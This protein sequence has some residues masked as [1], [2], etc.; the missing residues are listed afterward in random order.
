MK[1]LIK[2]IAKYEGKKHQ[3]SVGD[4]RE[5][6]RIIVCGQGCGLIDATSAMK[7]MLDRDTLKFAGMKDKGFTPEQ[8]FNNLI[9]YDPSK[10]NK[11]GKSK[12]APSKKKS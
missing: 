11:N 3:A 9:G 2:F 4:I 12:K 6:L 7:D 8:I 1:E 10:G 5:I